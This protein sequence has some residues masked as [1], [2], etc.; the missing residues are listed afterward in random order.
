MG[1]TC[2]IIYENEPAE[3][4]SML[5]KPRPFTNTFFNWNELIMSIIQ[6]LIITAGTLFIYQYA[7]K[8]NCN[9]ATTRSMV[10][11]TLVSANVFLTLVN[12]SFYYSIFTTARYHNNLV[13]DIIGITLFVT[14][15]LLLIPP[16]RVFFAFDRLTPKQVFSGII[17]GMVSVLWFE[18]IKWYKRS[19][20]KANNHW[21]YNEPPSTK[22]DSRILSPCTIFSDKQDIIFT[23][24]SLPS[25]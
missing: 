7:V 20:G 6:G 12:R 13:L 22:T 15:S 24:A 14:S 23:K 19:K 9:E 18:L 21:F 1:P 4:N 11:V 10:F 2:S 25:L 17:I 16:F 5:Q 8:T 3:K